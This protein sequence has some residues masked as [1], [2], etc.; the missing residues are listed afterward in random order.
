MRAERLR[1]RLRLAHHGRGKLARRGEAADVLERGVSEGA[2]RVEGQV[3]AGLE[4]D[5]GAHV[6]EHEGLEAG[7]HEHVGHRL[8]TLRAAAVQLPHR[9]A[10]ALDVADDAGTLDL[11]GGIDDA[12][13][14]PMRL[15]SLGE[16]PS[17]ID[18]VQHPPLPGAFE[19]LEVPPGNPVLGG[20]HQGIVVE[21]SP[22]IVDQGRELMRLDAQ[23]DEVLGTA[24]A[25]VR[26]GGDFPGDVLGAVAHHEPQS[27]APDGFEVRTACHQRDLVTGDGQ[28][29]P[30][31]A[32]DGARPHHADSHS[33]LPIPTQASRPV[34]RLPDLAFMA[35][36]RM[37]TPPPPEIRAGI[38]RP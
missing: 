26:S 31:H 34:S 33:M 7:R 37:R 28:L 36:H 18:A 19:P 13:D 12:A 25:D 27:P 32:P 11:R 4:P 15:D 5:L 22:E 17:R 20:Q 23:D 21:E 14:N 29:H 16:A 9:E 10:Q 8:D 1:H 6:V 24:G 35:P 3:A 2:D 38:R 30:E